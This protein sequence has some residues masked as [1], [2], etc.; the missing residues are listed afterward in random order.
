MDPVPCLIP[1]TSPK[2]RRD[3]T[4]KAGHLLV[5]TTGAARGQALIPG[6][7][8]V[9]VRGPGA[10]SPSR[11]RAICE[12]PLTAATE[13]GSAAASPWKRVQPGEARR[14]GSGAGGLSRQ[15]RQGAGGWG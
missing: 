3:D 4:A 6:C 2:A 11:T 9:S 12:P 13:P 10:R 7:A 1:L 8:C 14:T 5:G 15:G